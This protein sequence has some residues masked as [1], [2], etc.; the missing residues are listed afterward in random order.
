[1][2]LLDDL[3]MGFGLKE[4]TEDYDARTARGIA[5]DDRYGDDHIAQMRARQGYETTSYD[6]RATPIGKNDQGRMVYRYGY[7]TSTGPAAQ[8]L[9]S[10]GYDEGYTPSMGGTDPSP[11]PYA[12]GPVSMDQPLPSFGLLGL[13]TNGLGGL[14]SRD[15]G[16]E[17][18]P[19]RT[20]VRPRLRPDLGFP[21]NNGQP[22]TGEEDF[23]G[24][25]V[26]DPE[27]DYIEPDFSLVKPAT[28]AAQE[29]AENQDFLDTVQSAIDIAEET[30]KPPLSNSNYYDPTGAFGLR[31]GTSSIIRLPNGKFVDTLTGK[32]L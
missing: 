31:K 29:F 22:E 4:R 12:I 27:T 19:A 5:L 14:F 16:S 17:M 7:D 15:S 11:T 21:M 18:G 10:R 20:T 3:A 8:Y 2:G 13:F 30:K 23:S 1:M 9:G 32:Y 28:T 26:Y 25:D 24:V 6:P